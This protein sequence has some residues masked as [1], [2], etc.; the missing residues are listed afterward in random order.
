[1]ISQLRRPKGL[2]GI[3]AVSLVALLAAFWFSGVNPQRSK[4]AELTDT[5][6]AK[7]G[8]LAER[9]AALAKPS[10]AVKIR[11]SD[12]FR[13]SKA[14]PDASNGASV[15]LDIDRLAANNKLTFLSIAPGAPVARPAVLQQPYG[16]VLEGRFASVSRFLSQ[17]RS[18]VTVR[19]T[20]LDVRGRLY[21]IDQVELGEP[22]SDTLKFPNV[23]ASVTVN[24]FSFSAPPPAAAD[25]ASDTT[26]STS[27]TG[28]V[29]AGAT[30]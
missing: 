17:L 14:L 16:L 28:T 10:A 21:S 25:A 8:E 7:Q 4:A 24:A 20:H 13:L 6:A 5:A 19:D 29:A 23:K 30:P 26:V 1:M 18:L 9:R 12:L 11:A 27:S 22:D 3:G 15:L 2:V